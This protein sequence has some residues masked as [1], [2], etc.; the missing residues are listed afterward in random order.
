MSS[1]QLR[2]LR[3]QQDLPGLSEDTQHVEEEE[4]ESEDEPISRP[5]RPNPFSGFTALADDG[6]D[7]GDDHDEAD[8]GGDDA[9]AP[10]SE[11]TKPSEEP[12]HA[13]TKSKKSKKKKKG[14]KKG[15]NA[16][17]AATTSKTAS[18]VPAAE[19]DIDRAL[20]ELN[21]EQSTRDAS[22]KT[23]DQYSQELARLLSI[24]T[25]HLKVINEMRAL[26][27]RETIQAA[28]A[29]D[30]SQQNAN[31][32]RAR[33]LPQQVDLE[34][35]LK[36]YPGRTI[37]EVMMRR[38]PFVQ[39]KETWPRSAAGGLTMKQITSNP[40]ANYVEYAFEHDK[41][42]IALEASFYAYVQMYDPMRIVHFLHQHRE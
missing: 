2:K 9:E 41:S 15:A 4:E 26:F 22:D 16:D 34:T 8:D 17:T 40:N 10:I 28:A 13:A 30:D 19:D 29:E 32:R 20:A 11:P 5:A 38:N 12:T 6:E 25:N 33:H 39:G 31:Q 3:K 37:S 35:Y 7:D 36:G 42:Y 1:R 21:I 14:K 18:H 27:G 24:T 23:Q